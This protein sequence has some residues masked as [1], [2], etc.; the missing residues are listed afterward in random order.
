MKKYLI[1]LASILVLCSACTA[2][3]S[4]NK[5][6]TNNKEFYNAY[7]K[8]S[9]DKTQKVQSEIDMTLNISDSNLLYQNSQ[10]VVLAQVESIDGGDTYNEQGD[11]HMYPYT[12][13]SLKVLEVYKGD[14]K[15]NE[16]YPFV[17]PGG[18]VSF[19]DYKASL[20]AEQKEKTL[21]M[22]KDDIPEYVECYFGDD[23]KIKAGTTYLMYINGASDDLTMIPKK[24]SLLLY[25]WEG[26]LREVQQ[27]DDKTKVFNNI[28]GEWEDLSKV[29]PEK[30]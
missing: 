1:T 14:L 16:S 3:A 27:E 5:K 18:T 10:Y 25:G 8:I 12:Y 13:G 7:D 17:R 28:S 6:E 20:N 26:G 9:K 24:G 23:I 22:M 21:R 15:A 4:D 11:Y 29:L 2:K 30:S 19:E